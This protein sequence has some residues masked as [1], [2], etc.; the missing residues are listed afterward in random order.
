MNETNDEKRSRGKPRIDEKWGEAEYNKICDLARLGNRQGAKEA[1]DQGRE[2]ARSELD[3]ALFHKAKGGSFNHMKLAYQ[4]LLGEDVTP[5]SNG[6]SKGG[7]TI[8]V[9]H[10]V[11][12]DTLSIQKNDVIEGISY[13]VESSDNND[14]M[15]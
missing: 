10:A 13:E 1:F 4:I 8:N 2:I 12:D 6:D 5:Q 7:L 11:S 14:H 3:M 15:H 9:I